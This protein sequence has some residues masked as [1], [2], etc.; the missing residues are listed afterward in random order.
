MAEFDDDIPATGT[1]NFEDELAAKEA[2]AKLLTELQKDFDRI[3]AQKARPTGGV[4]SVR[5][6]HRRQRPNREL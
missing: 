4:G 1:V 2:E 3:K 5:C 6:R